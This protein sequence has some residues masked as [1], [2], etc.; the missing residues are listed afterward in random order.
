MHK[1]EIEIEGYTRQEAEEKLKLLME[2]GSFAWN[3]NA[4]KLAGS[5]LSYWLISKAT[6]Q[7]LKKTESAK[8]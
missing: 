8:I 1:F 7:L 2:I 3:M 6:Q 5:V 4:D